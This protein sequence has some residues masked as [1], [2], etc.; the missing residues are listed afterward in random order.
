METTFYV[1]ANVNAAETCNT[2]VIFLL[3]VSCR[4]RSAETQRKFKLSSFRHFSE[5][6]KCLMSPS[7]DSRRKF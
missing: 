5:L 4:I 2:V 7:V 1:S 6:R 3:H